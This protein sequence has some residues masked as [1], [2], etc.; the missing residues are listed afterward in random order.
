MKSFPRDDAS[1]PPHL[2]AF[3]GYKAGE[4][5]GRTGLVSAGACVCDAGVLHGSWQP[6]S[7]SSG[8]LAACL[9]HRT[10]VRLYWVPCSHAC[11]CTVH[12]TPDLRRS[13]FRCAGCTHILREVEKPGSKL[14]KKET[15]EAV[16]IIE[17]RA[18]MLGTSWP[19]WGKCTECMAPRHA[20]RH[21]A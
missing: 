2:T 17:V 9:A 3:I 21:A 1:K 6:L 14:H 13:H 18:C 8:G 11:W 10:S 16:T 19:A 12:V 15:C 4:Q 5:P 7:C 20:A